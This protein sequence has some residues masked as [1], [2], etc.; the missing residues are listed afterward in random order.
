MKIISIADL[1]I[2]LIH[3]SLISSFQLNSFL[4]SVCHFLVLISF[5]YYWSIQLPIL[6][7]GTGFITSCFL[8]L[9]YFNYVVSYSYSKTI[10][11]YYC[12]YF[13]SDGVNCSPPGSTSSSLNYSIPEIKFSYS[14]SGKILPY[15]FSLIE[16]SIGIYI[17]PFSLGKILY[18]FDFILGLFKIIQLSQLLGS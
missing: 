2:P 12:S 1:Y 17:D 18:M 10:C 7:I 8:S 13:C 4:S 6:C 15:S 11:N 16:L 5:F 14:L 9:L 3:F